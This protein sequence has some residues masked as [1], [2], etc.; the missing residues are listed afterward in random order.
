MREVKLL[1][2]SVRFIDFILSCLINPFLATQREII[3][4]N[5]L[6]PYATLFPG[7]LEFFSYT[8]SLTTPPCNSNASWIVFSTPVPISS[9]DLEILRGVLLEVNNTV[10]DYDG[11]TNRPV[12]PVAGRLITYSAS[13]SITDDTT[14]FDDDDDSNQTQIIAYT[15]LAIAIF[16]TVMGIVGFCIIFRLQRQHLLKQSHQQPLL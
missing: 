2:Q 1:N 3:S 6:N 11:S 13:F 12:V 8:G 4:S 15:A 9:D 7:S 14:F 16:A 5:P 10:A